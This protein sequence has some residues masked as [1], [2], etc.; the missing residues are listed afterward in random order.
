MPVVKLGFLAHP[1]GILGITTAL[2]DSQLSNV[3]ALIATAIRLEAGAG[4]TWDVSGNDSFSQRDCHEMRMRWHFARAFRYHQELVGSTV[5]RASD[6]IAGTTCLQGRCYAKLLKADGPYAVDYM[7][8]RLAFRGYHG[9]T[10]LANLRAMPR[11]MSQAHRWT[12]FRVVLN[13]VPSGRRY[14]FLNF[15]TRES[16]M[17]CSG[18]EDSVEHY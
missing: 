10:V 16:C 14:R 15:E 12:L 17:F 1:R 8:G 18:F 7:L 2:R 9:P 13:A 11:S 6:H 3:A 4:W 5:S